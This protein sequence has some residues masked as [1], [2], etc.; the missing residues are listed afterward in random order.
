MMKRLLV[1]PIM[2]A[3]CGSAEAQM[4]RLQPSSTAAEGSRIICPGPCS[5][6]GLQVNTGASSGW[7]LIFNATAVPADGAVVPV[8]WYQVGANQTLAMSWDLPL[9]LTTG[10]IVVFSTTG[11]FIKT[12][13]ATATISGEIQ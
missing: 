2:L 1:L 3:L 4:L 5:L 10:C 13:S 7:V 9:R 11:P 12:I 6:G 8:K